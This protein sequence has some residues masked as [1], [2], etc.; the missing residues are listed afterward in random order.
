MDICAASE[1]HVV[2]KCNDIH[3]NFAG[4]LGMITIH[5]TPDITTPYKQIYRQHENTP[6]WVPVLDDIIRY[7]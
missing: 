4:N 7:I 2:Y 5:L 6:L 3:L 1:I